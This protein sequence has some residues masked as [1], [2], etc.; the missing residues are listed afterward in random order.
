MTFLIITLVIS[1]AAPGLS[2]CPSIYS[3]GSDGE[4]YRKT[5]P[6]S[7]VSFDRAHLILNLSIFWSNLVIFERL[8]LWL[9]ARTTKPQCLMGN[10]RP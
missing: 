7:N 8:R 4:C 2:V 5:Q 1:L 10:T 3:E 9:Y 6:G